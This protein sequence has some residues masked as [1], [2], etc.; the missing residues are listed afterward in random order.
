MTVSI[1]FQGATLRIS[2]QSKIFVANNGTYLL[3]AGEIEREK[4][5]K[6]K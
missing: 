2:G 6:G 5:E 4:K 1:K 3:A